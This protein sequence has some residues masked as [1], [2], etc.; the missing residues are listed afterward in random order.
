M[1]ISRTIIFLIIFY[2]LGYTHFLGGPFWF[3][4]FLFVTTLVGIIIF[5]IFMWKLVG[6]SK[7]GN[8]KRESTET[9]KVDVKVIE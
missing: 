5:S 7:K 4:R 1:K 3:A 6:L 8:V 9:L 2:V